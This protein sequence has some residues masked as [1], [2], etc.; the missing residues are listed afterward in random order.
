MKKTLLTL[1][2]LTH[3]SFAATPEQVEQYISVSRAEEEL[4]ALESQFSAMQN[5]FKSIGTN[6]ADNEAD[7]TYDMQL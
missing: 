6:K 1:T 7:N 4:I 3:L 2:L 5:A